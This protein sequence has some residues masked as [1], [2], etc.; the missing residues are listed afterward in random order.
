[1][2]IYFMG[3]CGTAMGNAAL[4]FRAMG[5]TVSGSN[6]GVYPPMSDMLRDAGITI[7][8]GWDA[9][10]LAKLKPDAVVVGNHEYDAGQDKLKALADAYD[11]RSADG[12][13]SNTL[14]A[15]LAIGC[16]DGSRTVPA[17]AALSS[18]VSARRCDPLRCSW[19][20]TWTP[21]RTATQ[22]LASRL[23]ATRATRIVFV[24]DT[25]PV[26]YFIINTGA[27]TP[28]VRTKARWAPSRLVAFSVD[29]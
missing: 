24:F 19:R 14:D 4:L 5:H 2:R 15:F 3:I 20:A 25:L 12:T 21:A 7:L 13:Y 1:M 8:E 29:Q 28:S 11:G 27:G 18:T 22:A 17:D 10:R 9:D 23:T 26:L 16:I 6:T